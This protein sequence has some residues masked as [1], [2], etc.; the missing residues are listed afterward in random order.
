[1]TLAADPHPTVHYWS[2]RALT[3]IIDVA[4]LDFTPFISPCLGL[5]AKINTADSHDSEGGSLAT[6]SMRGDLPVRQAIC[7]VLGCLITAAGPGLYDMRTAAQ[8]VSA[9]VEG[10]LFDEDVRV[11]VQA[12][13]ALQHLLLVS[14]PSVISP[15][16]TGILVNQLHS[17]ILAVQISAV[18]SI[19]QVVRRDVYGISRLAGDKLVERLFTIL[20]ADPAVS[21]VRQTITAWMLQTAANNPAGWLAICQKILSQDASHWQVADK[22]GITAAIEDE[23]AQGLRAMAEGEGSPSAQTLARWQ[24]RAFALTCLCDLLKYLRGA[25]ADQERRPGEAASM[26]LN[27]HVQKLHSKIPDLMRM[28]LLA[29]TSPNLDLKMQGLQLLQEVVKVIQ[30]S[31]L[32][33]RLKH[34][35]IMSADL[36]KRK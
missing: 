5:V 27:G 33:V 20:D 3:V 29:C 22:Q 32:C 34:L 7:A 23:E 4:N 18:N 17:P 15:H 1:M 14:P 8:A 19:Y 30:R 24:T 12:G 16:V 6:A 11:V 9:I 26:K 28:A 36:W 2:L 10:F 35:L 21:G 25:G 13:I 31:N